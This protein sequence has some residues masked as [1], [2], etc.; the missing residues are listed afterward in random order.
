LKFGISSEFGA[1]ILGREQVW[2][3]TRRDG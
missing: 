1:W 2:A 3:V